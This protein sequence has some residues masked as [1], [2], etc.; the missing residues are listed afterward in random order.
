MRRTLAAVVLAAVSFGLSSVAGA[1]EKPADKAKPGD[2]TVTLQAGVAPSAADFIQA[3]SRGFTNALRM[4]PNPRKILV[5]KTVA[6]SGVLR[7][8]AAAGA[9]YDI[10][11]AADRE[12]IERLVAED[13]V[14]PETAK[15]YATGQLVLWMA[16]STN[17]DI[18]SLEGLA[19]P[20]WADRR[21]AIAN[22][23]LAP[24]GRAARA[25]LEAKGLYDDLGERLI[26]APD[27]GAAF[28]FA[29]T[30]NVEAA[31]IP[32]S[33][34]PDESNGRT[35]PIG[36]ELHPPLEMW[37]GITKASK[38]PTEAQ[39]FQDFM[40]GPYAGNMRRIVRLG[41][42]PVVEPAASGS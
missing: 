40:L 33:M 23:E 16:L 15:P 8:Q 38:H 24:F 26:I 25:V 14:D 3:V 41:P 37:M 1:D 2:E 4:G 6:A 12:T 35:I 30:G 20:A 34:V 39:A 31:F 18:D 17:A 13:I 36:P 9:P 22:P 42:P 29:R 5:E 32:A 19:E 28:H 21:I 27:V 10:I 11:F 7:Q